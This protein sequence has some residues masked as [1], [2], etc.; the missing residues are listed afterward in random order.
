MEDIVL[1][2]E[3]LDSMRMLFYSYVIFKYEYK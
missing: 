1:R 2:I 3:G